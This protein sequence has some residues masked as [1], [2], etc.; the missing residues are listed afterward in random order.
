MSRQKRPSLIFDGDDTL[1]ASQVFYDE[2]KERFYEIVAREGGLAEYFQ[3]AQLA[4]DDAMRFLDEIEMRNIEREGFSSDGFSQ[5]LVQAYEILSRQ[6]GVPP[7]S[8]LG[9]RL[10]RLGNGALK[11]RRSPLP[12]TRE[13]LEAL[14]G[15]GTHVLVLYSQGDKTIQLRKLRE[16]ELEE[17][18]EGHV[19]IA[20][21]KDDDTLRALIRAENLDIP[22]SWMIGNSLRSEINP[23]LR[24][25][26]NCIWFRHAEWAYD[27][28]EERESGRLFEIHSLPEAIEIIERAQSPALK[29]KGAK[30]K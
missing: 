9:Q 30:P 5:S 17:F 19:H 1:W 28:A 10:R 7:D 21:R 6:A 26:L 24:L 13:T 8:R 4:V 27:R 2:A 25:G 18:F 14:S 3:S 16:T 12:G 20:L 22:S 23:A 29:G 15:H 11:R